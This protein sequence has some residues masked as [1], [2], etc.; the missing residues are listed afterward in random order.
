[1]A[2]QTAEYRDVRH[3]MQ[4]GDILAFGGKG[5]FSELIKWS[6]RSVVL[7]KLCHESCAKRRK[8]AWQQRRLVSV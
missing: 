8:A 6:T 1:M 5:N 2:M 3:L 7:V 4:P